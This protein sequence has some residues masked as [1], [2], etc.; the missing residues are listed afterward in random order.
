MNNS[1]TLK[2][3]FVLKILITLILMN[4]AEIIYVVIMCQL[5]SYNKQ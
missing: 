1:G 2:T 5:L 3:Y 4:I